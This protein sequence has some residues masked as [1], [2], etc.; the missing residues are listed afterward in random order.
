MLC[1]SLSLSPTCT[2]VC[3]ATVCKLCIVVEEIW[4]QIV[5]SSAH[6]HALLPVCNWILVSG[7]RLVCVGVFDINTM[8]MPGLTCV[9]QS[10][11]RVPRCWVDCGMQG[12]MQRGLHRLPSPCMPIPESVGHFCVAML[13][14]SFCLCL[15][16]SIHT[17]VSAHTTSCIAASHLPCVR[18]LVFSL[19]THADFSGPCGGVTLGVLLLAGSQLSTLTNKHS[20]LSGRR[21]MTLTHRLTFCLWTSVFSLALLCTW[22]HPPSPSLPVP[23][24]MM[25]PLSFLLPCSRVA[26]AAPRNAPVLRLL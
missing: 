24:L 25:L 7:L 13:L 20:L 11:R 26:G 19:I 8:T 18:F 10:S 16:L 15:C 21:D 1:R 3:S 17:T 12:G 5:S 14:F 6:L 4:A 2:R 22:M 23:L 9:F